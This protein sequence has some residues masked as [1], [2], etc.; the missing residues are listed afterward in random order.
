MVCV[1]QLPKLPQGSSCLQQPVT[2][3]S[4]SCNTSLLADKKAAP[5]LETPLMVTAVVVLGGRLHWLFVLGLV[6]YTH[7]WPSHRWGL[8]GWRWGFLQL[9]GLHG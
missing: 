5:N 8:G 1:T 6:K 2:L 3:P 9:L 4:V 7:I